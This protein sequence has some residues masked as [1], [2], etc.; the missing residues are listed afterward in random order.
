MQIIL[1]RNIFEEYRN[2]FRTN[3]DQN[4][5]NNFLINLSRFLY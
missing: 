1:F 3:Y 2:K 5:E 4:Q